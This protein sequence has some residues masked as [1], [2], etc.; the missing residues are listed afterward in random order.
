MMR[1]HDRHEDA[2]RQHDSRQHRD[3]DR[4]ADQVADADQCEL[5]ADIDAGRGRAEARETPDVVHED[6]HE[7]EHAV[8]RADE[9]APDDDEQA[10]FVFGDRGRALR[11]GSGHSRADLQHFG[12]G[13]TLGVWQ[14]ATGHHRTAQRHAVHDAENSAD[15][16][17][18]KRHPEREPGPPA[19]HDQT[20]EH[21]DDR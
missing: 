6:A 19:D 20:R 13:D 14:V 7:D 12:G 8:G 21:E 3:A 4:D 11:V 17:D 5:Q 16:A 2:P 9:R 1:G 18:R 10:E 15:G